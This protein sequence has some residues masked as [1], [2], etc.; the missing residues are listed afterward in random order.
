[1]AERLQKWLAGRGLGSRREIERWISEGRITVDGELA[2][3]GLKVDGTERIQVD[4]KLVRTPKHEQKART[5]I[6]HKPPGEICTRS[7]PQ[8]RR[9]VFQSLPKVLGGRWISVG[10]LDFQTTGLLMLTT[11]GELAHRLMHPSAQLQREYVVRALGELSDE[12]LAELKKG[13]QLE[14]GTAKFNSIE[15]TSGEGANKSYR[16]TVSEGRNRI[17]RRLFEKV[18]CR[19]NRL[20]RISFGPIKLPRGLRPGKY[21]ELDE[22][23]LERLNKAAGCD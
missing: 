18:G 10:R 7:D 5:L 1:M 3:L 8:G 22:R 21:Q 15:L 23:E 11:D 20:M 12:Q 14:D 19:V 16:V 13:V 17:V 9:T 2:E 4:G 6:Y